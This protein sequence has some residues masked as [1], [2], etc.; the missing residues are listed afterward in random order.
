M[1]LDFLMSEF[2]VDSHDITQVD[3]VDPLL[4]HEI[5]H[6]EDLAVALLTLILSLVYAH[7][8]QARSCSLYTSHLIIRSLDHSPA[9]LLDSFTGSRYFIYCY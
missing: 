9:R 4:V 7:L 1:L 8:P 2:Y 6:R 3:E 5:A